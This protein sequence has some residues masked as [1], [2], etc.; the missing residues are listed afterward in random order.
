VPNPYLISF[1]AQLIK[2]NIVTYSDMLVYLDP[3]DNFIRN[4]NCKK[5][6]LATLKISKCFTLNMEEIDDAEKNKQTI[7]ENLRFEGQLLHSSKLALISELVRINNWKDFIPAWAPFK[8][9]LDLLLYQHLL[10][11]L[12]NLIEWTIEPLI[13]NT[14]SFQRFFK[15]DK[16]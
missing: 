3:P 4:F 15:F 12:L 16:K 8:G 6:E 7:E 11:Y 2:A 1:T 10:R 5:L 9:K 13:Q 14:I